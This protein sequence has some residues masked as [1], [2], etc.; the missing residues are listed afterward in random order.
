VDAVELSRDTTR[1][2][3]PDACRNLL[4]VATRSRVAF[5]Q[6]V[7]HTVMGSAMRVS[8]VQP[9]RIFVGTVTLR[10]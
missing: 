1:L 10:V 3:R 6:S 9:Q 7:Q 5:T 8:A 4:F 2:A